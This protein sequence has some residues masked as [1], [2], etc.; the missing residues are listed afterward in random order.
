M[1]QPLRFGI[2]SASSIVE[3][4]VNGLNH[5]QNGVAYALAATDFKRAQQKADQCDI[6]V[7]YGSYEELYADP[8]VDV[9]YIANIN[10]QHF[11]Q[12]MLALSYKKHVLC[13][14]PMVLTSQQVKEAFAY[15]KSQNCFLMEAQKSVFLPTTQFIKD[16]IKDEYY[17][18]LHQVQ[19]SSSYASR[20]PDNHWMYQAHQGGAL[21]GS[22]SYI[23]EFLYS[24][25]Q[26][27]QVD[28]KYHK[29][30]SSK[31]EIDDAT[32]I[33][34]FDN[35]LLASTHLTTRVNTRNEA[36]F[37]FE[38]ALIIIRNFWKASSLEV[39]DL[40]TN[41][42]QLLNFDTPSEMTYE[43]EHVIECIQNKL[44][45]SPLMSE[46]MTLACVSLVEEI[47]KS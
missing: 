14:K 44:L 38:N 36:S 15:A 46:Y 23:I 39:I 24:I 10:D 18:P 41:K 29:H 4:F 25:I 8:L 28:V 26:H 9:V 32:M 6:A 3:R 30:L 1:S 31:G 40:V 20:H 2:I 34:N 22:G 5:T 17:G 11:S 37:Y 12:I 27:D 45:Q 16:R 33:F 21:F 43:I 19:I 35:D 13:E 47:A 42:R 7:V